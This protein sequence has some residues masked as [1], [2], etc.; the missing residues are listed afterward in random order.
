VIAPTW[1]EV[2]QELDGVVRIGAVNCQDEWWLCNQQRIQNYPSLKIYPTG[3]YYY[4]AH[5]KEKMISYILSRIDIDVTYITYGL[6]KDGLFRRSELPWII[7]F[8]EADRDCISER[9]LTKL[10]AV[11]ENLV[12]VGHVDCERDVEVCKTLFT[13][14]SL[15]FYPAGKVNTKDGKLIQSLET[16]EIIEEVI[17]MLPKPGNVDHAMFQKIETNMKTKSTDESWLLIFMSGQVEKDL[18]LRKLGALL[19]NVKIGVVDCL[20]EKDLCK[21]FHIHKYPTVLLYKNIGYEFHHGRYNAFDIATFVKESLTSNVRVLGAHDFPQFVDN[22]NNWFIDF[23]APWCPPCMK[24]LPEWRK[25]GKQIGG[26]TAEFGTVDCTIHTSLCQQHGVRSYPTTIFYNGSQP[27]VFQGYHTAEEIIDFAE[28]VLNPPVAILTP[29]LFEATVNQKSIGETWLVDFYA[30]WCGPCMEL[31]P[32]YRKLA[33]KL[34]GDAFLGQ[35]DCQQYSYFCQLQGVNAYPTVRMY[36]H[37]YKGSSFYIRH[38]GWRNL[39]SLYS[40]IFQYFPTEVV[41]L[42][43]NTFYKDVLQSNDAWLVDFY[44]PWCG[45]CVQ[46]APHYSKLAKNLKGKIK[47]GKVNCDNSPYICREVGIRAYPSVLFYPGATFDG[48]TQS[49]VGVAMNTLDTEYLYT[50]SL[51]LLANHNQEKKQLDEQNN[52][53]QWTIKHDEF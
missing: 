37:Q 9:T 39:D 47:C 42:D 40:W 30:P 32:I 36:P 12:K 20:I 31:A 38:Q 45:H 18:E 11:L 50:T 8:C 25:A 33:K 41:E 44:A 6:I 2:A 1:R 34:K 5:D 15:K 29:E 27:H 16:R 14:A 7:S 51:Q 3:E 21:K 46:F 17:K 43:Q 49:I 23:Y 13:T 28:D 10:A 24:L 53:G 4:D 26:K 48:I 22:S 35:I 52:D 19:H